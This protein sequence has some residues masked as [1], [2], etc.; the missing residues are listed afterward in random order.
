[1]IRDKP[2]APPLIAL[3]LIALAV[4]ASSVLN[5][6]GREEGSNTPKGLAS[7]A[8]E[9]EAVATDPLQQSPTPGYV[10]AVPAPDPAAPAGV[11]PSPGMPANSEPIDPYHASFYLQVQAAVHRSNP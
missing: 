8:P 3:G 4:F 2:W 7:S 6:H 1:M 10:G 9:S 11:A 5:T